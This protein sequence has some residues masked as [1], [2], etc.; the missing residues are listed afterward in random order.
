MKTTVRKHIN[1]ILV[2][3]VLGE[4]IFNDGRLVIS[5]GTLLTERLITLLKGRRIKEIKIKE[6][7]ITP[8]FLEEE[9]I[10]RMSDETK[11][12]NLQDNFHTLI[13]EHLERIVN[14]SR[15]GNLLSSSKDLDFVLNLFS[16]IFTKHHFIDKL[17][18]MKEW[19]YYT[20]I[21]SLD[22]FILGSLLAKR[23]GIEDLE[24]ASFGYL[25]HDI[26]KLQIPQELLTLERK[27][28]HKEFNKMKAHTIEGFEMLQA[29][30]LGFI[31]RY[32]KSHHERID[33]SG[34]P[35]QLTE[36]DLTSEIKILQIV[37]V[38][39]ALTLNRPY[40]EALSASQALELIFRDAH[41]YDSKLLHDFVDLL[42]IYPNNST[43]LLSDHT[44]AKIVQPNELLPMFPVVKRSCDLADFNLPYNFDIKVNKMIKFQSKSFQ[45]RFKEVS[46]NLMNG[47]E[48]ALQKSF[49]DLSDNLKIEE[50]YSQIIIP[51][52]RLIK[53]LFDEKMLSATDYKMHMTR[54]IRLLQIS[55]D[56]ILDNNDYKT[57]ALLVVEENERPF[58]H[59]K[60]LESLLHLENVYPLILIKPISAKQI[61][62]TATFYNIKSV[63]VFNSN[64][65]FDKP[66]T[67]TDA[68]FRCIAYSHLE[69]TMDS[70][71]YLFNHSNKIHKWLME[72]QK[73]GNE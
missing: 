40:R 30:G 37:D 60:I 9:I 73:C 42:Q 39:S 1:E 14:E 57:Q 70:P 43:V 35:E 36:H 72:E 64:G 66:L 21:H 59:L 62:K 61:E 68:K 5:K 71:S 8:C 11:E 52:H 23:Q 22:V 16:S 17:Y 48:N 38:Y 67:L 2:N 20:F 69:K 51:L 41:Q 45:E 54:I 24:T 49:L 3:D 33:G 12:K 19:D 34:Y 56:S 63:F 6:I 44:Y 15:Y 58:I 25:F 26:G 7:K 13:L 50:I 55:E 47:Y 4:D 31:A 28:S 10:E 46:Q 53:T 65:N 27:L 29:F 18:K 32:A